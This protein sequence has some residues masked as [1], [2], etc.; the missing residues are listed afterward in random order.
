[1]EDWACSM[2]E[3]LEIKAIMEIVLKE[4]CKKQLAK[5]KVP[6]KWIKV[7]EFPR[8]S[9]GKIDRKKMISYYGKVF[10]GKNE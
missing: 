4:Q 10:G 6:N 5:F 7:N 3:C 9:N 1:M 2:M 8:T